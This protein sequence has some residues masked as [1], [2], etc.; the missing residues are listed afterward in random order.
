M[1]LN[2]KAPNV[3]KESKALTMEIGSLT[4]QLNNLKLHTAFESTE[5]S[6]LKAE[7]EKIGRYI[8]HLN[9][10]IA[11]DKEEAKLATSCVN[12]QYK[13]LQRLFLLRVHEF[14]EAIAKLRN[15]N[16]ELKAEYNRM[17]QTKNEL[18]AEKDEKINRLEIHVQ[19]LHFQLE[20]VVLEMVEKLESRLDQ[21]RIEW[22]K[23]AHD[24]H[25]SP[26][27]IMRRLGFSHYLT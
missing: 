6:N 1:A 21:D 17:V 24:I 25:D 9:A 3:E 10:E 12:T 16:L 5:K 2:K 14:K 27:E 7:K 19:S 26:I 15:E 23:L 22:E 11:L 8:R 20:K 18:I 4:T 13:L